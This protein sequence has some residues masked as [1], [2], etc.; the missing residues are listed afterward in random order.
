MGEHRI[1]CLGKFLFEW[2]PSGQREQSFVTR[3]K[4]P[5][6]GREKRGAPKGR[7]TI[8]GST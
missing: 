1:N 4:K 2:T 5:V 7:S 3:E 6:P 8:S